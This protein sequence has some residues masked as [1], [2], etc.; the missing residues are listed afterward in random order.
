LKLLS[1]V[2]RRSTDTPRG[3][4]EG[5]EVSPVAVTALSQLVLLGRG[6]LMAAVLLW[7]DVAPDAVTSMYTT[8]LA[9]AG[10]LLQEGW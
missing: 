1:A 7:M 4:T 6:L 9:S 8:G 3:V 2:L 10:W 5:E